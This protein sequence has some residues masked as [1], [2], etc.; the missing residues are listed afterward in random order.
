MGR[1]LF[2]LLRALLLCYLVSL[3]LICL[4]AVLLWKLQLKASQMHLAVYGIYGLSCLLGGLLFGHILEEKRVLWGA[5]FG[6]LY[7]LILLLLSVIL[8]RSPLV[9]SARMLISPAVCVLSGFLG[10]LIS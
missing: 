6:L 1:K 2:S 7:F 4:S 10:A 5:A 3:L 8:A 9:F